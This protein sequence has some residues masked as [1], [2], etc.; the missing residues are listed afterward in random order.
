[1]GELKIRRHCK[2]TGEATTLAALAGGT[3]LLSRVATE[4][5]GVYFLT[6][7]PAAAD[8][9]LAADAI[10]LYA[11]VQRAMAS[12]AMVLGN[13]RNL[14]AGHA[15]AGLNSKEG[16]QAWQRLAGAEN[17]LS[18]EYPYCPGIFQAG[19]RLLAINRSAAEDQAPV[20]DDVR[21]AGL[22]QGLDFARF[23]DTAG[24]TRALVQEIWRLLLEAMIVFMLLEALLCMPKKHIATIDRSMAPTATSKVTSTAAPYKQLVGAEG[25]AS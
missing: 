8:S 14:V 4:H 3:P 25:V 23:D 7:T 5:G 13:T 6:T 11:A 18:T 19:D 22:F 21:V 9:A 20:L 10:V 12:G 24:S 17:A 15:P 2:L 1:M 16:S